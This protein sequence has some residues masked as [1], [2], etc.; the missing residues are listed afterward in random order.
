MITYI[1]IFLIIFLYLKWI[2]IIL[3]YPF[4]AMF[5]LFQKHPANNIYK[6]CAI[7]YR[8][9]AHFTLSGWDKF[10]II[11]LGFIPS[12]HIRKWMY[13]GLG[14]ECGKYV[15]FRHGIEI[16]APY[17]LYV[18]TGSIIGD[19]NLLD[20]RN[21]IR[22]G[23]NVNFSA[24]VSVYTEQHDHRDPDF[25][26]GGETPK[27]VIIGDR[28]WLGPNVI[29]LPGVEIGEGAVCCA[30]CVVT[31]NVPPFAVVAGVP[32]KQVNNRPTHLRYEFKGRES[33]IY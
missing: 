8:I 31:K 20:A 2:L 1:L 13:K 30:G 10:S 12:K 26:C 4:Q 19:N 9:I 24:N 7:P 16:W 14:V 28:V 3:I 27:R 23:C 17:R 15:V 29:V 25:L 18:G 6:L 11:N 21:T 5:S 33:R 32:A 22:I